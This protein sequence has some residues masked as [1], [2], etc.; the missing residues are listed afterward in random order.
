[1]ESL[2]L[3]VLDTCK[4]ALGTAASVAGY[5]MLARGMARDILPPELRAALGRAAAYVRARLGASDKERH[6]LVI[7][8][9]FDSGYSEN[10]L[11]DAARKYLTTKISPRTTPCLGLG[12]F[13]VEPDRSSSSWSTLLC[14][15]HDGSTSD[16]FDGVDVVWKYVR[17][18]RGEDGTTGEYFKLSFDAKDAD[19]VSERYV[20]F[21]MSTAEQLRMRARALKISK[22]DG[23]SW[24]H[25]INYHHPA[26]FATLAM[27]PSLKQAVM[28]DL[29]RF[30]KRKEYYLRIG[31]PWKRGYLL[32]GPPGTGKSSLVA[33]MA[34]YLRFNLYDLDLSV[35]PD[36]SALQMLLINM[37]NKSILVIEDID[38]CFDAKKSREEEGSRNMPEPAADPDNTPRRQRAQRK[39]NTVTL[40]GLLNFIDGLWSTSGEERIIIFTTNYKERLDQALLRPGRMDMHVEMGYCRWEAFRTLARNYHLV[41]D[42]PLFPEI[43]QLLKAVDVT[44]AEVSEMLLRK[45][46]AGQAL[47]VLKQFLE[48]KKTNAKK[49]APEMK[50]E[51]ADK[52]M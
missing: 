30:L 37:R 18:G 45:E 34:N 24:Q 4:K 21:V 47:Q 39:Q 28:D 12:L 43:Q 13:P 32:Y 10:E 14:L 40:S 20:P 46:D 51:E 8:R 19:T 7:R 3:T 25:G 38:C 29:D 42:H 16:H 33:A 26:T 2:P 48:G 11:F 15:E 44:P 9:D 17:A 36:N 23:A 35:V 52:A 41:D 1:M 22:N 50:N 27:D 49:E 31:K 6:A 5:V